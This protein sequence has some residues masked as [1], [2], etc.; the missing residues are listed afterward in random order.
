VSLAGRRLLVVA[1]GTRATAST[2]HRLWNYRPYLERD[3]VQLEW[4]EYT[5]G[6]L[7]ST[8]AALAA[9]LR[10]LRDLG[11]HTGARD[12]VLVQKV[13]PPIPLVER[14]RR[15]G[16]RV[17]YDFD[18]ALFERFQ[19]GETEATAARRRRRFDRMLSAASHVLAG[20]PPLADYARRLNPS[21]EVLYPSLQRERF[22]ALPARAPGTP[23][24]IGWVGNDQ[25]QVYLRSLEP[26]LADV[27]AAHPEARLRVCSSSLPSLPSLPADRVAL[28]PWSEAA[29]LEAVAS[30]DVAVSPLGSDAWSQARGGRVSVLLSL[31]AGVPVVGSPGGGLEELVAE[32]GQSEPGLLFARDASQWR[33]QLDRVLSDAAER[34]RRSAAAR[35]LIDRSIWADAQYPRLRRAVFQT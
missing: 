20:S 26:V 32:A 22:E 28:V 9:R 15:A 4:V 24:V 11:R 31:A 30:F 18:D 19:W 27:L 34:G 16:A 35:A 29:E 21:V 33:A 12:V 8:R 5:G 17:V 25:S 23:P 10:F 3:G 1:G 14:W 2:R 13:L 6:R 7:E